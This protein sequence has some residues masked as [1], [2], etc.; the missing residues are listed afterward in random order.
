ML[1]ESHEHEVASEGGASVASHPIA[2]LVVTGANGYIGSRL[3]RIALAQRRTVTLLGRTGN[4]TAHGVR[5][6]RWELGDP[7][8]MLDFPVETT[9]VLHLAHDWRDRS[10]DG[11]NVRGTRIL[12][13]D[14]RARGLKRFVFVSSQSARSDALNA[15]GRIKWTIEQSLAGPDTVSARVGLVYG[16]ARR[17]M[18]GLLTKLVSMSPLL[19]MIDPGRLVQPIHVEEVCRGLLALVEADATGWIGLAGPDPVSFRDFLETLAQEGF[20]L[21]VRILPIPLRLALLAAEASA[22][23]PFGPRIDKERILGLAGT[24]PMDCREHLAEIG[25]SVMPLRQGL[26]HDSIGAKALLS[27]ARILCS[28]ILENR[29]RGSLLRCYARAIRAVEPDPGP[30]PLPRITA[31]RPVLLRFFEPLGRSSGLAR[32]LRIATALSAVSADALATTEAASRKSRIARFW[33]M[34]LLAGV[35]VAAFPFRLVFAR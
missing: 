7:L 13:Q 4:P 24:Q 28:F 15:Y 23:I 12:L 14:A 5:F 6:A 21:R 27:E 16:G 17:G 3:V 9:A 33:S 8:P 25:L 35:E 19:P 31:L 11:R 22:A 26:R 2:H 29:V 34:L 32:R 20:S 10:A 18:Y 30:L 1:S